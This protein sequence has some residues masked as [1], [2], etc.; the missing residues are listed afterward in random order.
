MYIKA[1]YFGLQLFSL[2]HKQSASFRHWSRSFN[3]SSI[4]GLSYVTASGIARGAC[5]YH[6]SNG[7]C[8]WSA[9]G[10]LLYMNS[11]FLSARAQEVRLLM[12][13]M[14]RYVWISRFTHSVCS[15]VRLRLEGRCH[16]VFDLES[17]TKFFPELWIELRSAIGDHFIR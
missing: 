17:I 4:L 8:V 13:N 12:Q 7:D 10:R 6:N 9:W 15:S 14:D 5:L 11:A 1:S 16:C 3:Q 2:S